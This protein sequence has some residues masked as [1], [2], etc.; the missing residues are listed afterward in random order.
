MKDVTKKYTNGEVTVIW[1]SHV[2]IHSGRCFTGL[3]QVFDP[4]TRPWVNMEGANTQEIISQV[5]KCPSRAL[6]TVMNN[7]VNVHE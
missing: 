5:S 3:P 2:C 7:D 4:M 1:K 6:T